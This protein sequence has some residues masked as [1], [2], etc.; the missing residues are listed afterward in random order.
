MRSKEIDK[1]LHLTKDFFDDNEKNHKEI[2]P[3][4]D[5]RRGFL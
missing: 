3:F 1:K 5:L 2:K 4:Y